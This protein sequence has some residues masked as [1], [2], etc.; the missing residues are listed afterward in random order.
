VHILYNIHDGYDGMF[1][2]AMVNTETCEHKFQCSPLHT[3]FACVP[4]LCN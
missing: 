4:L 2:C 1:L 3:V